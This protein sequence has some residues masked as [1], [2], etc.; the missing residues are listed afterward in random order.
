MKNKQVFFTDIHKAE[1][2]ENEIKTPL[3]N[4]ASS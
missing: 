2:I 4:E 1:L 3:G